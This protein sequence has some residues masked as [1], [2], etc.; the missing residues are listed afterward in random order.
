MIHLA[1]RHWRE[2]RS[3]TT[4]DNARSKGKGRQNTLFHLLMASSLPESK[5]RPKR[6]AHEGF[7]VLLAGSDTAARTIGIAAY[8]IMASPDIRQRLHEELT[9]VMSQAG[10][11]VDLTVLEALL[12]LVSPISCTRNPD[13]LDH[14]G[15]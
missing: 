6:M 15:I 11:R 14:V 9:S 3:Q 2:Y 4:Q 8:H 13:R 10:A 12:C 1:E 5:K 7:E